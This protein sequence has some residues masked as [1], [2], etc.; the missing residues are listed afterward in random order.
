MLP[1]IGVVTVFNVENVIGSMLDS[2]VFAEEV[3]CNAF[4]VVV[5]FGVVEIA[6][7]TVS[8]F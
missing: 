7:R 8:L 3:V 5:A 4:I 6:V 1:S 2:S